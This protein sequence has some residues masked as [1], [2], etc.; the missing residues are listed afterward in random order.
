MEKLP[1]DGAICETAMMH[2]IPDVESD[3]KPYQKIWARI[4]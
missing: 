4:C 2:H 3:Q 1:E